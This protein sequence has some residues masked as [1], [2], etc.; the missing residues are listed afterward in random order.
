MDTKSVMHTLAQLAAALNRSPVSVSTLQKQLALP[1]LA[2]AGYSAA[3][4]A[5]L[6]TVVR[7][8][9]H[10]ISNERLEEL[11]ALEKKLLHLLHADATDSPTW[12]LDH[13]GKTPH[14]ARRLLLSNYDLGRPLNAHAVQQGLDFAVRSSELFAGEEM[15]EDALR[16]LAD[17][18]KLTRSIR[19]DAKKES[20]HVRRAVQWV[21][22]WP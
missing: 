5:F 3:Y 12:F 8:R 19:A 4:L 6:R 20:G 11:W 14:R 2:G 17:C 22:R 15:G 18:A 21:A 9:M 7:L 16:V 13:C 10:N 1:V